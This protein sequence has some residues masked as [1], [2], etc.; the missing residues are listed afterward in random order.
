MRVLRCRI[1]HHIAAPVPDTILIATVTIQN[2]KKPPKDDVLVLAAIHDEALWKEI[3][4][5]LEGRF[6]VRRETNGLRAIDVMMLLKPAAVI[7]ETGLP[8][9]SGILLARLLGHN[10]YLMELPVALIFSREF[11]IEDFW[12]RESGAFSIVAR[13]DA[14]GAVDAIERAIAKSKP[15][16]DEDWEAAERAI[17]AQGGPAAAV[18]YELERQLIGASILAR[19]G[20][21]EIA[22]EPVEGETKDA[23]PLFIG[24]A[25][26]AL[27][28]ML[29]F[30]QAGI[31]LFESGSLYTVDNDVFTGHL[32]HETF[33]RETR[34]ASEIYTGQ[35]TTPKELKQVKLPMVHHELPGPRE[36][37]STFFALPLT[38]RRG[39]YGLL[40]L[41]TYK[42]I[43]VR[44]YYLNT[45]SLIG[46]QLAVNLERAI[47]YEE[48]RKLS[49]T[50]P[51]TSLSNRRAFINRLELEFKR[52]IRYRLPMS[53]A[54]F[55]LDDFKLVNDRYGHQ[56]GDAVLY[57]IA[58]IIRN[59]VR[60][61][62]LAGR[63][64]GEEL[65]M[66]FPQT[67]MDGA[68]V[69][70][71]RIRKQIAD[72]VIYFA[73]E[74][75]R[76]TISLGISTINPDEICPRSSG[77][78]IG[79]ADRA[80]YQAKAMGKNRVVTFLELPEMSQYL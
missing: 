49:V 8:D 57:D 74:K 23:I 32:D 11:L 76:I 79:L 15:I 39:I 40:S 17:A 63:W 69:A 47:F 35:G 64:G 62:D 24:H 51:L 73:G 6:R 16:P 26:A 21:I 7:A 36:P 44:E 54:I 65:A 55:D 10:R 61:I 43:A 38:G 66:L 31:V 4:A 27:A 77:A 80:L 59:S 70:C 67:P 20:E 56:A 48:V 68:I 13:K 72:H 25:L 71:E 75:L 58:E 53:F 1:F 14:L 30:A 41:M 22:T 18:A 19:L 45:L 33:A 2:N 5:H 29:E 52:S 50:D 12:A 42:Q 37:A 46:S 34:S 9:L 78:L 3:S 28:S 60:E